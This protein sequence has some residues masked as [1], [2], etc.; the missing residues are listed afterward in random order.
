MVLRR[1]QYNKIIS[2]YFDIMHKP[3]RQCLL[4][5]DE[6][7][8]STV[9]ATLSNKLYHM[10][11]NKVDD[12]D[13][14]DI[15]NSKGDI[16][17][18]PHFTE[19]K[20]CLETIREIV[21]QFKSDPS[22]VDEVL[23]CIEN[24][25]DSKEDIWQK[26]YVFNT[27]IV[28]LMYETMALSIVS[29]VSFLI[30]TSIEYIKDPTDGSFNITLDKVGYAKTRDCLLYKNIKKFNTAY[31]KGE[32]KKTMQP[33]LKAVDKVR[34]SVNI[35]TEIGVESIVAGIITAGVVASMIGLII[36]I[37]HE[38]T[39]MFFCSRQKTSEFFDIQAN[40][41]A[42]NAESVKLDYTKTESERNKIYA[43]Q[44]KIVDRLRKISN[45]FAVKIKSG[46][47]RAETEIR[48]ENSMKYTV[49]DLPDSVTSK[50]SMF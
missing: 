39:T 41:L 42:L 17:K 24:L 16:S 5:L 49:N 21:V 32:I 43:K 38:L 28:K 11:V 6:N 33:L 45:I 37:L 26:A 40:L 15:P 25:R 14:G 9:L 27:E 36:P 34:E 2:E 31:A 47:K 13:Y 35:V 48:K 18:I 8:K 29:S 44:M 46:Q 3:T 30:S 10:I 12:I 20:E 50:S 19:L 4:S 23:K 22:A 7:G 1:D